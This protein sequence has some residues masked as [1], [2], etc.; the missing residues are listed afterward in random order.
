M[1]QCLKEL[2]LKLKLYQSAL[3]TNTVTICKSK[4]TFSAGADVQTQTRRPFPRALIVH[5][6]YFALKIVIKRVHAIL[7][8]FV[9]D[10]DQNLAISAITNN[11]INV[12]AADFNGLQSPL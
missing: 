7:H 12:I 2:N 10:A 11:N 4:A 6:Y 3:D 5:T 1:C 9:I 8:V